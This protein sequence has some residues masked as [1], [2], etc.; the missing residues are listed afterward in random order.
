MITRRYF[1]KTGCAAGIGFGL[2]S[3]GLDNL[4]TAKTVTVEPVTFGPKH[5]FF[6]YYGISPWNKS[7]T[8][9]LGLEVE[10]QD[11]MPEEDE[12]ASI[13]IF[14]A[15]THK[16]QKIAETKAWNY[17]QGAI[18][19]WNPLNT[20]SE[21]NFNDKIGN[22]IVTRKLNINTGRETILPRPING[23]SYNGKY[24]LSLDYGR[25]GRLRQVVGY[26]GI[27]DHSAN[28]PALKNSEI[29]LLDMKTG[30]SKFVVSYYQVYEYL[31]NRGVDFK[32]RHI[33][34][35]HVVFNKSDNR[36]FFLARTRNPRNGDMET[37]M[38]TVNTD[39]SELFEA[40]LYG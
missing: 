34:F 23:F 19:H 7:E 17:Q 29:F 8:Y 3:I 16:F 1:I 5:H 40:I 32:G 22:Q 10:R 39:G 12:K 26:S 4:S 20:D 6:G 11:S 36:F 24:A 33:W 37:G 18:L 28:D 38:F 2:N 31:R 13:G 14:D 15:Q 30:K 9:L 21:I 27:V 25:L 35:N